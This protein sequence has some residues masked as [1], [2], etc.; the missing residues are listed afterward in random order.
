M[1]LFRRAATELV[2]T[3]TDRQL[4][5]RLRLEWA[6]QGDREAAARVAAD[7]ARLEKASMRKGRRPT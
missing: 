4:G 6:L 1:R 7:L 2:D 3:E 5:R